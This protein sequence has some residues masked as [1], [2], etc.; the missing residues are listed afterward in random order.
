VR[1]RAWRLTVLAAVALAVTGA[2]LMLGGAASGGVAVQTVDCSAGPPYPPPLPPAS[3]NFDEPDCTPEDDPPP[4]T[5]PASNVTATTAQL[6][7]TIFPGVGSDIHPLITTCAFFRYG[8]DP[9]AL[10]SET[11]H[12]C[13]HHGVVEEDVAVS[14]GGL[15]GGTTYYFRLVHFMYGYD[16]LGSP[17]LSF[18]T[19]QT[20]SDGDGIPD[21]SDNCPSVSN[22]S[23]ADLDHDGEGDA[24]DADVDGDGSPNSAD[25]CPTTF[26]PSQADADGDGLGDACDPLTDSDGDGVADAA[27]NC[28]QVANPGQADSDNDGQGDACDSD[29]DGDGV[30]NG[31]D[32]CPTVPNPGQQD[33]NR[34]GVGDDCEPAPPPVPSV[35]FN[36]VA[37]SGRVL[38]RLPG[39]TTF[40]ELGPEVSIPF[41]S[42]VNATDGTVDLK[43]AKG[44]T[45]QSALFYGG[46]FKVTQAHGTTGVE[47]VGGDSSVCKTQR[48]AHSLDKRKRKKRVRFV[49]GDG[50][51]TYKTV[52]SYS[53]GSVRG[54][55]WLTVD[56]CDGTYTY[57]VHGTVA[58]RDF[59][60][61]RT[62]V[63]HAGQHYL[64]KSS[65]Q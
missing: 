37:V 15:S 16:F 55:K 2:S 44:G 35:S 51:G 27:D 17:I 42:V 61:H 45:I 10:T 19:P 63:L 13:N 22:P 56:R 26:N 46:H 32:N 11:T 49:W 39:A 62:V 38:V 9:G 59:R 53:S 4:V 12:D 57:V 18:A 33:A 29:T 30:P 64:A 47:L 28:P 65:S 7:G 23:Q 6:N 3:E 21:V 54:T 25:N 48:A 14:I 20:D 34:N 5:L 36:V 8:T 24:C 58:V 41:G 40:S 52:G 1:R 60:L 50:K 31:V 43:T